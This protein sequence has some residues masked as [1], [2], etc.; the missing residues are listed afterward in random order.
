M[1][2]DSDDPTLGGFIVPDNDSVRSL[3]DAEEDVASNVSQRPDD[4]VEAEGTSEVDAESDKKGSPPVNADDS[5]EKSL[6]EDDAAVE[7][8]DEQ[9]EVK[10]ENAVMRQAFQDP[11]ERK[12]KLYDE[13]PLIR[14]LVCFRS[15]YLFDFDFQSSCQCLA[16]QVVYT[17]I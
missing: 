5:S 13:L 15:T 6:A 11:L 12:M 16:V 9:S 14:Y 1:S 7:S 17:K 2:E 8:E 3:S 10:D 4:A